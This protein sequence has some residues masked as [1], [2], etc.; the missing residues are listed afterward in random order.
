MDVMLWM[1]DLIVDSPRYDWVRMPY[2]RRSLSR[3]GRLNTAHAEP[4]GPNRAN[5][6]RTQRHLERRR[7]RVL[8]Y[9]SSTS[10]AGLA[11]HPL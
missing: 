9:T 2:V 5:H 6:V 11:R 3:L 4:V 10:R 1:L 7:M 8:L